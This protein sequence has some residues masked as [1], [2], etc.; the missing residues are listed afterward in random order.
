MRLQSR[1][2]AETQ[3]GGERERPGRTASSAGRKSTPPVRSRFDAHHVERNR[4]DGRDAV[5]LARFEQAI[6]G[7]TA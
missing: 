4:A 5:V 7:S 2:P 6:P 3:L 1:Q